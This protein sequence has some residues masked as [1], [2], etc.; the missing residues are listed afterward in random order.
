V[1][2]RGLDPELDRAPIAGRENGSFEV[3]LPWMPDHRLW[4]SRAQQIGLSR[5][6][7]WLML[8][9]VAASFCAC[10]EAVPRTPKH[11]ESPRSEAGVPCEPRYRFIDRLRQ[12]STGSEGSGP[13]SRFD[14]FFMGTAGGE[15]VICSGILWFS[16]THQTHRQE[17]RFLHVGRCE[18]STGP[19][20]QFG[21]QASGP[22]LVV[23]EI[24]CPEPPQEPGR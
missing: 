12:P 6:L 13:E 20:P 16:W 17:N 19:M 7:T 23:A 24:F 14:T 2:S 8:L 10:G 11:A 4:H 5:S 1:S 22:P 9:G 21:G 15:P 3:R 18:S